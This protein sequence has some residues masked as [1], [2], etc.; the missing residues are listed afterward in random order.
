MTIKQ[1]EPKVFKEIIETYENHPSI[2][3]NIVTIGKINNI[4]KSFSAREAAGPNKIVAK[5]IKLAANVVVSHLT[6]F[7]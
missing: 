5:V 2:S 6:K 7:N 3:I 4:F 1:E